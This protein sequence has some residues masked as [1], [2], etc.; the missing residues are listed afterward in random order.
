M[1]RLGNQGK[2][3]SSHWKELSDF[4][5]LIDQWWD[6]FN[7]SQNDKVKPPFTNSESQNDILTKI[8]DIMKESK[9]QY[10]SKK[11][12]LIERSN[13]FQRGVII[14]TLSLKNLFEDLKEKYQIQYLLTRRFNQDPL[15]HTFGILRQMGGPYD[16][17]NCLSFKYR[18]KKLITGKRYVL[19]STKPNTTCSEPCT[20]LTE[21][22][23]N[24][25]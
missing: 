24:T 20:N 13:P 25:I 21:K 6:I 14:S 7:A 8:I 23:S 4:I 16:N 11:G 5:L 17:P 9:V 3:N 18:M 19:T 22:N 12:K 15:E 2:L 1:A 10:W